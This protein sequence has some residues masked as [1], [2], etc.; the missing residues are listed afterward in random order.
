MG[1]SDTVERSFFMTSPRLGFSVWR[2]SDIAMAEKLWGDERVTRYICASGRFTKDEIAERLALEISNGENF[3]VQYW[4]VFLSASGEFIGCCG[5]RPHSG[6]YE[7]GFHL[8]AEF[9][10]QGYAF[11]AAGAVI[12]YA[13]SALGADTLFA[14]HNPENAASK[15]LLEKLG[16]QYVGDKFYPP[17]G[18]YHPS[19]ELKKSAVT[20]L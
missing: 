13:L 20:I 16:F 6:G 19:Y 2:E 11:E 9:W 7:L 18:L 1:R 8:R 17:T 12:H 5:L 10:G 15:K 14:G 4:P 3:G